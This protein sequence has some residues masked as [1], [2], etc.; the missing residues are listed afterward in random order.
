MNFPPRRR[1]FRFVARRQQ[2]AGAAG[3]SACLPAA[4]LVGCGMAFTRRSLQR[5]GPE[6]VFAKARI[7]STS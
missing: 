5:P 3:V 1:F 2:L 4:A 6:A 7:A